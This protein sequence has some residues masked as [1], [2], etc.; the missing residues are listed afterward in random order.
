[1]FGGDKTTKLTK[2]QN[3]EAIEYFKDAIEKLNLM[4]E[5]EAT[6]TK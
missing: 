3:K 2:E 5:A 6:K 4:A 1:M